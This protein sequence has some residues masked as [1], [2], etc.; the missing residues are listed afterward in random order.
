MKGAQVNTMIMENIQV[1]ANEVS[2]FQAM[3]DNTI[4]NDP[5]IIYQREASNYEQ[6]IQKLK[7]KL[8]KQKAVSKEI[9]QKA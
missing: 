7:E 6:E 9:A 5:A 1:I 3:E 2:T 8:K 4:K